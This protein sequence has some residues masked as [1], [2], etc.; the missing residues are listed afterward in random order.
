MCELL[1]LG[2]SHHLDQDKCTK[3]IKKGGA[4]KLDLYLNLN[5]IIARHVIL[6][7][8]IDNP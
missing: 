1:D 3:N 6:G 5:D 4:V 8:Y 7:Y 2:S